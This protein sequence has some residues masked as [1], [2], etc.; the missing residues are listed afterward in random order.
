[1]IQY[2][3]ELLYYVQKMVGDKEKAKELFKKSCDEGLGESCKKL[4]ELNF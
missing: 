1:M 4:K 3:Q 2:Y